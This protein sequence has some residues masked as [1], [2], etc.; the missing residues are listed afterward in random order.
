M[1]KLN[2]SKT[3][4]TAPWYLLRA[5]I[6]IEEAT[7]ILNLMNVNFDPLQICMCDFPDKLFEISH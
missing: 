7:Q 1:R 3:V 4:F 6:D 2:L 5:N